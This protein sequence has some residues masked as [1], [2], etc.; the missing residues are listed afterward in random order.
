MRVWSVR[1]DELALR[2][3]L[4]GWRAATS[5]GEK[6]PVSMIRPVPAPLEAMHSRRPL[7]LVT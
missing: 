6:F 2:E 1:L 4:R 3:W 5:M 7:C